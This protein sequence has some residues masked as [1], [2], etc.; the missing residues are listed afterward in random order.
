MFFLLF[1]FFFSYNYSYTEKAYNNW[2]HLK[3]V[4]K[5]F[6]KDYIQFHCISTNS[7]RV[8]TVTIFRASF[9]YTKLGYIC[10]PRKHKQFIQRPY[11]PHHNILHSVLRLTTHCIIETYNPNTY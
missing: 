5:L 6:S 4:I 8:N 10:Y 3:G 7:S 11:S 9:H 1:S 2:S